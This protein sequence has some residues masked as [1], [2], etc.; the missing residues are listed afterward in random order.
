M[1]QMITSYQADG[2]VLKQKIKYVADFSLSSATDTASI[3]L[4]AL[5]DNY[6]D[7]LVI[8]EIASVQ[9]PGGAEVVTGANYVTY[10]NYSNNRILPHKTYILPAGAPLTEAY[11]SGGT[12]VHDA[13]YRKVKWVE[14]DDNSY[15][16]NVFDD[17]K[18]VLG[19]HYAVYQGSLLATFTYAKADQAL[20]E[21]FEYYSGRGFTSSGAIV[22]GRTGSNAVELI[23]PAKLISSTVNKGENVYRVS[24]WMKSS[25]T[26][27]VTIRAKN[28]TTTQNTVTV[29]NP[30]NNQW[31]YLE[32][33]MSMTGVSS[34][35]NMEIESSNSAVFDDI[36]VL[37]R[38]ARVA[39]TTFKPHSGITSSTDD[40]GN[41]MLMTYDDHGRLLNTF[42]RNRNLIK[43]NEYVY[44][45][46]DISP[47]T[48]TFTSSVIGAYTVG[49]PVTFTA[50]PNCYPVVYSWSVYKDSPTPLA[51]GT[52]PTFVYTFQNLG[53][54][55]VKLSVSSEYGSHE[56]IHEVCVTSAPI[57][58]QLQVTHQAQTNPLINYS[59]NENDNIK[60]FSFQQLQ[61]SYFPQGTM[62][63][64][65]WDISTDGSNWLELNPNYYNGASINYPSPPSTYTIRCR[66]TIKFPD[67][68]CY[69]GNATAEIKV[70]E[71][72]ATIQFI[73]NPPCQ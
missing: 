56:F 2:S 12:I 42:D 3:A 38:S 37:P 4:K 45:N 29:Q 11:V 9:L 19:K 35:F 48:A 25:T 55:N 68:I 36:V 14:Y 21:G 20:Y 7:G 30:I 73:S 24:F 39:F 8:E 16:I 47:I 33:E 22:P 57:L 71:H 1:P 64:Y 40:R 72:F 34:V 49:T 27:T 32:T 43:H 60:T 41:S 58:T 51:T 28:G 66:A 70:I 6:L 13:D 62:I 10:R 65:R 5:K 44:V 59:C 46:E 31:T 54:Y 23:P 61:G 67:I 15:L 53:F 52:N 63:T 18:N 17:R 69:S 26:T 50:S